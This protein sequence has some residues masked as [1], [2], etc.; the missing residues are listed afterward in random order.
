MCTCTQQTYFV[1]CSFELC[2]YYLYYDCKK[3]VFQQLNI[4]Q[5]AHSEQLLHNK[6]VKGK[7][8]P[9]PL[10]HTMKGYRS[11]TLII[12]NLVTSL[13]KLGRKP[14]SFLFSLI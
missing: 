14:Q 13:I 10:Y 5:T 6:E 9:R 2:L 7:D 11:K 12:I 8:V 1:Q 4:R 3:Y